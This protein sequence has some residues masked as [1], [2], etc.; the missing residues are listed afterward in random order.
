MNF[1]MFMAGK[2]TF[3]PGCSAQLGEKVK[4][5][6]GSRVFLVTDK[7]MVSLGIAEK[8][9]DQLIKENFDVQ[10]FD[11]VEPE[12][13]V[14]TV[15]LAAGAAR[16]FEPHCVVGLGG[17]SCLDAAK[18]VSVLVTNEGSA[19]L[20]QGLGLLKKPGVPKILIPTTAGTGAEATFTSVLIRHSDG[21]KGGINDD[22][23]FADGALLDPELTLS[24]PPSVTAAT[25][26]D[27]FAH[28]MESYTSTQASPFSEMFSLAAMERI[29]RYL[30]IAVLNGNNLEARSEMLYASWLAGQGL[31]LAGV[32]ACHALSYPLGGLFHVGH[33]L[34]NALLLPYVA[35][36]NALAAPDKF[37]RVAELLGGC[38]DI[39][40]NRDAALLAGDLLHELVDDIGLPHKMS[41]L[42]TDM[43]PEDFP[44][45]AK[46]AMAIARPMANNPRPMSEKSCMELYK[47]AF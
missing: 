41:E 8:I 28:A 14:E 15:D 33:G 32:T 43:T 23:L 2:V 34:S 30:R 25:G 46:G 24:L 7:T 3:G 11:S 27:A 42:K 19:G 1:N 10:V 36:H 47:E 12:P 35:R 21:F 38:I 40:S 29:G 20:Y 31:A 16:A 9:K 26:M 17:G 18:A 5:L 13:S 39:L 44:R 4:A 22:A 45:M 37:A 6:G